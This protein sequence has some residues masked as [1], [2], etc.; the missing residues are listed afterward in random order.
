MNNAEDCARYFCELTSKP[1]DPD[2]RNQLVRA[3][4]DFLYKKPSRVEL[5]AAFKNHRDLPDSELRAFIL[6]K[7]NPGV[8]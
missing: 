5:A 6:E 2:L 3:I 8:A 1:D 7:I 4:D